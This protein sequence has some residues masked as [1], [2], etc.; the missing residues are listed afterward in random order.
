MKHVK[1]RIIYDIGSLRPKTGK[2]QSIKEAT[3]HQKGK[4]VFYLQKNRKMKRG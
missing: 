2:K 3:S 1:K 4:D